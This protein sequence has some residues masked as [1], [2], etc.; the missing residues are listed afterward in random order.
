LSPI[1]DLVIRRAAGPTS[2]M[3][4]NWGAIT[5][6]TSYTVYRDTVATFTP[7]A[8]NQ[9]GTSITNSFVDVGAVNLTRPKYFYIV[10]SNSSGEPGLARDPSD[11]RAVRNSFPVSKQTDGSAQ[12]PDPASRQGTVRSAKSA[13]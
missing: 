11:I 8:G 4:L 13:K 6:A 9:V 2:N 7:S 12:K 5:G 10:T 3:Q 1:Q